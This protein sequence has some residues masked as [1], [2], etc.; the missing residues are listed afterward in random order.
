[1]SGIV[2]LFAGDDWELRFSVQDPTGDV[3]N[4][5]DAQVLWVLVGLKGCVAIKSDQVE[6]TMIDA[7]NGKVSIIVRSMVTTRLPGNFYGH[8]LRVIKGGV[9]TTPFSGQLNVMAD[10]WSMAS[11][12]EDA[13]GQII[14]FSGWRQ[15]R[16]H[17]TFS[18]VKGNARVRA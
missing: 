2:D 17:A 15:K 7:I 3:F 14:D 5:T 6:V 1:M 12:E 16:N 8:V 18:V 4:L 9:T 11:C 10:P 13:S